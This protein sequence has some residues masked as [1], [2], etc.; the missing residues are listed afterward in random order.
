MVYVKNVTSL[1]FVFIGVIIVFIN[2]I[3]KIGQVEIMT[4]IILFKNLK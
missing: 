4:L 3:S 1:R 2:Q